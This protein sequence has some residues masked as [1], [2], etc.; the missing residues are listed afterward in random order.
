ME[1]E[2]FLLILTDIGFHFPTLTPSASGQPIEPLVAFLSSP[3]TSIP[4][5]FS[6][7]DAQSYT[8]S[9]TQGLSTF[10]SC[11]IP[12]ITTDLLAFLFA[13]SVL[14]VLFYCLTNGAPCF[15]RVHFRVN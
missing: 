4:S 13:I 5:N 15:L 2:D 1:S 10:T 8:V 7:P 11:A 6:R 12:T 3:S 14:G 9:A